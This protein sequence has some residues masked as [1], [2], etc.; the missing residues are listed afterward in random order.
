MKPSISQYV[1]TRRMVLAAAMCGAG[2][3]VAAAQFI[4][5][6]DGQGTHTSIQAAIDE[7]A[8]G[9]EIV[10]M[11]G[12]YTELI[13]FEGKAVR[14]RSS[15]P[16][17]MAVV[18]STVIDG[19][20]FGPVV[21]FESGERAGSVLHGLT[22]RN[23][24]AELHGGGIYCVDDSSPRI[25]RNR[26][27][28]NSCKQHG[29]GIYCAS[30][31]SP[32][33]KDNVLF[34]NRCDSRGGGIYCKFGAP[35]IEGNLIDGNLAGCS[36]G[37]GIYLG[38]GTDAAVVLSN[39]I[40][41]NL[42]RAGG[43]IAVADASPRIERNRIIGNYSIPRGG[44]VSLLNADV[45]FV[46]NIVAG[47]VAEVGAAL[48][49]VRS[50]PTIRSNTFVGNWAT[51]AG[52]LLFV[53][54][55]EAELIGNIVAF[56]RGGVG[57]QVL[58][59]SSA[60]ADYNCMFGNPEG[61]FSGSIN[62]GPNN[63]FVDP[64]LLEVGTWE[65]SGID[66]DPDGDGPPCGPETRVEFVALFVDTSPATG[67]ARYRRRPDRERFD[68]S[69]AG[70]P[71]GLHDMI[72]NETV[73]GR[74]FVNQAGSGE[75]EF[76]T[77]D[78][79]FPPG[80]PELTIG[81]VVR[82]AEIASAPFGPA[83][84]GVGEVWMQ[85][86]EHLG[87]SSP[88]RDT[89]LPSNPPEDTADIDGQPRLTGSAVDIG[90]DEIVPPGSGDSDSDGDVDFADLGRF[91]FCFRGSGEGLLDPACA[92]LDLDGDADVDFNDWEMFLTAVTGPS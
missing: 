10:V 74:I 11:P 38:E 5:D 37:G 78:G 14:V 1:L 20:G 19:G 9:F 59:G 47:N 55:S 27:M 51:D 15:A 83:W 16:M 80:F 8:D 39:D 54:G 25:L 89:G 13:N 44:G 46:S 29:G 17:D 68:V 79:N 24:N 49:C 60:T 71:P 50:S 52:I 34:G 4:V 81:D 75:L 2:A 91:Q 56:S 70:F 3:R 22:I 48:D 72:I 87:S 42:C 85:G 45:T 63:Q 41:R 86:E 58:A 28:S 12:V 30:G 92:T 65:F 90:G 33:I 88:C 21:T 31:S 57:V 82:I 73:V 18:M 23:G 7:S 76:D 62:I 6:L 53:S 67:Y 64:E 40:V 26:I 84:A 61:D 77:N 35:R 69:V 43:G 32:L 36:T 66:A